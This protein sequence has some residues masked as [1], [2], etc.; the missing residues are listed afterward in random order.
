M[1]NY[2][3]SK[4][5]YDRIHTTARETDMDLSKMSNEAIR[6][7]WRA[8]T[9]AQGDPDPVLHVVQQLGDELA[10]RLAA[11][12]AIV[13]KTKCF[14]CPEWNPYCSNFTEDQ[15]AQAARNAGEVGDE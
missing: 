9:W 10:R 14:H 1:L 7:R 2:N 13:E 6:E 8:I 12:E 3:T 15:A 4:Y 5:P 11:A